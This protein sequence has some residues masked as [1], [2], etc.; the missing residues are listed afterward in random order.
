MGQWGQPRI[1]NRAGFTLVEVLLALVVFTVGCL[2]L[3]A[4]TMAMT[5]TLSFS[6]K[7]T[8]ATTLAQETMEVVTSTPY[9]NIT[10]ARWP[11]EGY[12]T[13]PGYPQF[14]REV[15]VSADTPFVNTKTVVITV[16]W[17]RGQRLSPY[18][19]AIQTIVNRP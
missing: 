8:T 11:P 9:A 1:N 18:T 12:N 14:S 17:P 3:S 10:P 2:G 19:V 7:L 13:I 4:M 16:S 15:T 6:Q 5:T